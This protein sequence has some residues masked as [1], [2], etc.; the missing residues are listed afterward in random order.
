EVLRGPGLPRSR[1]S[2]PLSS[3]ETSCL[4]SYFSDKTGAELLPRRPPT[5]LGRLRALPFL[6]RALPGRGAPLKNA[7]GALELRTPRREQVPAAA[8]EKVPGPR[9]F[10]R[11]VRCRLGNAHRCSARMASHRL[12]LRST[13]R[14]ARGGHCE[15]ERH[16]GR[17]RCGVGRRSA[18]F[19]LSMP[20]LRASYGRCRPPGHAAPAPWRAT[21]FSTHGFPSPWGHGNRWSCA[22]R[23]RS[24]AASRETYGQSSGPTSVLI[25]DVK[26]R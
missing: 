18:L 2:R 14:R 12:G 5:G 13:L 25:S 20:R 8:V 26:E 24:R 21:R 23:P 15:L 22:K 9:S 11:P 16:R 7:L 19:R 1:M 3:D 10:G 17:T 4:A 6:R